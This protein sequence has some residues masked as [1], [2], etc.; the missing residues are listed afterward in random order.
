[1]SNETVLGKLTRQMKEGKKLP[2]FG[3]HQ[4]KTDTTLPDLKDLMK[5]PQ[6]GGW[7][8]AETQRYLE[9]KGTKKDPIT[10]EK[11]PIMTLQQLIKKEGPKK[12]AHGGYVKK[13]ARGG[14]V[15]K[16]AR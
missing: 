15:L 10:G 2:A 12:K 4:R 3:Y 1:M 6:E 7:T 14:G 9:S 5:P 13:Y 11:V 8:E 16:K